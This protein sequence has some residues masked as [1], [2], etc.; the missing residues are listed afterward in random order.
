MSITAEEFKDGVKGHS[1]LRMFR[2][3]HSGAI[4]RQLT[5]YPKAKRVE[6]LEKLQMSLPLAVKDVKKIA[7][8]VDTAGGLFM[9][10][11][12]SPDLN[13]TYIEFCQ[14]WAKLEH[15][16]QSLGDLADNLMNPEAELPDGTAI[17]A[18]S[19]CG[20]PY[21]GTIAERKAMLMKSLNTPRPLP[22]S[23]WL[24]PDGVFT[25]CAYMGHTSAAQEITKKGG[26]T[27]ELDILQSGY[28]KLAGGDWFIDADKWTETQKTFV[29]KQEGK[30]YSGTVPTFK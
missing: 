18:F 27:A 17:D 10:A 22:T 30:T 14:A 23:G 7:R 20:I 25:S 28:A 1:F 29:I 19:V 15:Q 24:S 9:V 26:L 2:E 11:G 4:K 5:L 16:L 3:K 21:G 6:I 13:R 12:I 8:T